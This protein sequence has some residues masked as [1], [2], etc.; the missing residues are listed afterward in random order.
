MKI[1]INTDN[2]ILGTE[3]MREP[4]KATISDALTGTVNI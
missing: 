2:N 1:L 3:E 4:L